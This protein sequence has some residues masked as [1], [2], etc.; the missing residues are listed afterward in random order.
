MNRKQYIVIRWG[1][2]ITSAF[3]SVGLIAWCYIAFSQIFTLGA[4]HR[5]IIM[6]GA[7][8]LAIG[9]EGGSPFQIVESMRRTG[10][11]DFWGIVGLTLS[12]ASTVSNVLFASAMLTAQGNEWAELLRGYGAVVNT[13]LVTSDATFNYVALTLHLYHTSADEE[14]AARN[15]LT[16]QTQLAA[17]AR[18]QQALHTQRQ[19]LH[20]Q[21]TA[22]AMQQAMNDIATRD[23]GEMH[24][25]TSDVADIAQC[26]TAAMPDVA[27]CNVYATRNVA[28]VAPDV[29]SLAQDATA[30][31]AEATPGNTAQRITDYRA[32]HPEARQAE[33]ARS[34]GL[35]ASA[36]S[37]NWRR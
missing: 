13:I 12:Q 7:L 15:G 17:I 21:R 31:N 11:L 18:E 26:N 25:A 20:A 33:V 22:W 36:V 2:I 4:I 9:S 28:A 10:R 19:E 35:S 14:A 8:C 24:V 6:V 34:L 37:R 30:R 3:T 32:Q 29:A 5:A 16:L 27:Q 23:T 1:L